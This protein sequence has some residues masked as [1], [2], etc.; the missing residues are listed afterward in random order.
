MKNNQYF[1]K[2]IAMAFVLALSVAESP[3]LFAQTDSAQAAQ[4]AP[5]KPG[6]GSLKFMLS[7]SARFQWQNVQ[8]AG[9]PSSNNFYPLGVMLMPLVK[10]NDHMLLDAQIEADQN[11]TGGSV[12]NLNELVIYYK[13]NSYITAFA[14]NFSPRY[15]TYLGILDDFTNRYCTAPI[16]MGHGPQGQNGAGFQGALQLGTTK[17]GYQLY[18]T[19]APQVTVDTATVGS[20]N[21]SGQMN[22]GSYQAINKNKSYGGFLNF[23]PLSNSS[24][25]LGVSAL[26]APQTGA[27]G[28]DYLDIN[29][30]AIAAHLNYYHVF[31]PVMV[32]VLAEYNQVSAS[33]Y[34]YIY[35]SDATTRTINAFD[36][37]LSGWFA[38]ATFRASGADNRFL[39]NL[40]LGGRYGGYTPPKDASWGGQPMT[41]TTICL[42]YWF[43]FHV[44]LFLAYDVV[45]QPGSP[46]VTTFTAMIRHQF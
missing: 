5:N 2:G 27:P 8:V 35:Y 36:N 24:L 20:A 26:Y 21:M 38:G 25:E 44:P 3:K 15:G 40:E 17:L 41:Q 12:V 7:G 13:L 42:T 14:G 10:L 28:T 43:S 1:F 32:R 29:Y 46:T 19:N 33:K 37:N 45:T 30:T 6:S 31:S 9:Q 23:L 39:S 18:V 22:F 34:N 4:P 11:L 16:G